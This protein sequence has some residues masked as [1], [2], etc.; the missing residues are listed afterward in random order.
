[1]ILVYCCFIN[2]SIEAGLGDP[3]QQSLE[4]EKLVAG[5]YFIII[6]Y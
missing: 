6:I 4:I 2:I 5:V 3:Y 1:M